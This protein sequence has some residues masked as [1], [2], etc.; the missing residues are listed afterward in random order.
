[1]LL[2]FLLLDAVVAVA[3]IA[4]GLGLPPVLCALAALL[5]GEGVAVGTFHLFFEDRH[6]Y[7]E[8]W[9]FKFKPDLFSLFDGECWEDWK[10]EFKL[11]LYHT[12]ILLPAA[13]VFFVLRQWLRG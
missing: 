13:I 5:V 3:I 2:W 6:A 1:M 9:K 12:L 8:A 11:G 10:A 7:W 4:C